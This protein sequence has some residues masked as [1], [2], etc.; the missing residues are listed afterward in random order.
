MLL[1]YRP[2]MVTV[3]AAVRRRLPR[4]E[5]TRVG[6]AI[7]VTMAMMARTRRTSTNVKPDGD[8]RILAT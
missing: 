2:A 4:I 7:T 5:C 6:I 1:A 3:R 8:R